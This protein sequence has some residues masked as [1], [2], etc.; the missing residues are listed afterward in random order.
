MKNNTNNIKDITYKNIL[1][2]LLINPINSISKLYQKDYKYLFLVVVIASVLLSIDDSLFRWLSN[3]ENVII[4]ILR[5]FITGIVW[6]IFSFELMSFFIY[7]STKIFKVDFTLKQIQTLLSLSFV[8][9]I[10]TYF[11]L[12][13]FRYFCIRFQFSPI[14]NNSSFS[15]N[16]I[17]SIISIF[18]SYLVPY[19]ILIFCIRYIKKISFSKSIMILLIP[20]LIVILMIIIFIGLWI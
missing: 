15:L 18:V 9:L 1:L 6:G 8:Y 11:I 2:N 12:F 13:V 20:I 19:I 10:P 17:I 16:D 7:K 5:Q 3:R 14:I 4:D